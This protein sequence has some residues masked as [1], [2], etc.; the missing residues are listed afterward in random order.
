MPNA[1]PGTTTPPLPP[2]S[3]STFR[4]NSTSGMTLQQLIQTKASGSSGQKVAGQ[5]QPT[6][7]YGGV[8]PQPIATGDEGN[9]PEQA[10]L[11]STT[12][13]DFRPQKNCRF[14]CLT[15]GSTGFTVVS[16]AS[17]QPIL[18]PF[19]LKDAI[20][21]SDRIDFTSTV[22]FGISRGSVASSID[23]DAA[24]N[25]ISPY[26]ATSP[27]TQRQ[28]IAAGFSVMPFYG[29]DL[30]FPE[31]AGR[32]WMEFANNNA[33]PSNVQVIFTLEFEPGSEVIP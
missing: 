22:R 33:S 23:A 6:T 9:N 3:P 30:Y 13:I 2:P 21:M 10:G 20:V 18:A 25:C 15:S 1:T 11:V 12:A 16:Y 26:S 19:K 27:S 7:P 17:S 5:A 31:S 29:L 14:V 4:G 24:I 32:L 28:T 8:Y